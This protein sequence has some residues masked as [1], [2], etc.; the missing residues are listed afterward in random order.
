MKLGLDIG[1]VIVEELK[2]RIDPNDWNK[3]FLQVPFL[4]G[5]FEALASLKKCFGR[6][7]FIVSKISEN[8]EPLSREYLRYHRFFE[9][10]GISPDHLY[11]CRT[12]EEKAPICRG[13]GITDFVDNRLEVLGQMA[14]GVP[15]R[16]LFCPDAG[17]CARFPEFL[18]S[19]SIVTSWPVAV[20]KILELNLPY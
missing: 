12:R 16:Y 14:G 8:L 9:Q 19:V 7:I 6:E 10:A 5:V 11:Y 3:V 18:T 20:Q 2:E 17:E 4:A 13:L 15:R 1:G